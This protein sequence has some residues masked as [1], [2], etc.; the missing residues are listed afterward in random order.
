MQYF[1]GQ[2]RFSVYTPKSTAWNISSYDEEKYLAHLYSDERLSL[3]A[4]IFFEKSLPMLNEMKKDHLYT[5][6]ISYSSNLPQKWKNK[7]IEA[8]NK[9]NFIYL[10]EVDTAKSNPIHT[11]L[12]EFGKDCS[13]AYFRLDDDDLLSTK[14]LDLLAAYN[15]KAFQNMAVSF[16]LGV[17]AHYTKEGYIDFRLCNKKFLAIG[18]AY[19]GNY[20]DGRLSIPWGI[21]HH[22]LEK[23]LPVILDSREIVYLWTLH[24]TQ[25]SNHRTVV[26]DASKIMS[27]YP[28]LKLEN[29]DNGIFSCLNSE[30][31]YFFNKKPV[32]SISN[33]DLDENSTYIPL[34][35]SENNKFDVEF[36][37]STSVEKRLSNSIVISFDFD[38]NI[39]PDGLVGLN[40]SSNA[41]IKWYRYIGFKSGISDS[42]FNFT[43][44]NI[45]NLKG[46]KIILWNKELKNVKLN[47]FNI[48]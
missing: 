2:T 37:F 23:K 19:I 31:D 6:I 13:V 25:D 27:K 21:S 10:H 34:S 28:I 36:K 17:V 35:I 48:Y 16:G 45:N 9:Y 20:I 1:I 40:L 8:K 29:Y 26:D 46:V 32:F 42:S 44:K 14:Y 24:D 43:L 15:N 41:N 33:L 7:L 5:H 11:I 47:K 22:D 12:S 39:E 4:S 30:L 18:Q 38:E 3:R